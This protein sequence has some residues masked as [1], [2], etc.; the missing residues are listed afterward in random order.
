MK[1]LQWFPNKKNMFIVYWL[2]IK[3]LYSIISGGQTKQNHGNEY[4]LLYYFVIKS[5]YFINIRSKT[6]KSKSSEQ[7]TNK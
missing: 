5:F 4:H 6:K 2:N 7:N 1:I 3:T